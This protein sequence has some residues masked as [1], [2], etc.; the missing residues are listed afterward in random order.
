MD[1]FKPQSTHLDPHSKLRE[2]SERSAEDLNILKNENQRLRDKI[3]ELDLH[4]PNDRDTYIRSHEL[5]LA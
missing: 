2:E 1:T 3:N 4:P 5:Q